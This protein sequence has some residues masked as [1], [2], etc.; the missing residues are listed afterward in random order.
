MQI[1]FIIALVFAIIVAVF[2]IQNSAPVDIQF[3]FWE[4][5][6][7][8]QVLVI[9]GA[10]IVGALIALSISISKQLRLILQVRQLSQENKRLENECLQLEQKIQEKI[11][12]SPVL[13]DS[14][15][16]KKTPG[17]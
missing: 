17:V 6:S 3:L 4:V 8:S 10:A 14:S 7:I 5:P 9:L 13:P 1:H 11:N 2:A 16:A 12:S 15:L